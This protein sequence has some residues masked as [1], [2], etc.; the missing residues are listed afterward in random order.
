MDEAYEPKVFG[1]YQE[2]CA[3]D[4]LI[5]DNF[6]L[7][8]HRVT[9]EA[10]KVDGV[11]I[12]EAMWLPR[13]ALLQTWKAQGRPKPD[14]GNGVPLEW[15]EALKPER[16]LVHHRILRCMEALVLGKFLECQASPTKVKYGT[17]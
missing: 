9:S 16:R 5:N 6:T 1:G 11:E 4:G 17:I 10:F 12:K 7:F 13:E 2:C 14:K 8:C 3:R 15:D